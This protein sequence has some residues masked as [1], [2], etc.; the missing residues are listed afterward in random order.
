VDRLVGPRQ[1]L[2]VAADM[3]ATERAVELSDSIVH[4]RLFVSAF[5]VSWMFGCSPNAAP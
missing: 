4:G 2:I 1:R 3:G 5:G